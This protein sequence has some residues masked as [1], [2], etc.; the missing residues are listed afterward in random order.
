MRLSSTP[1]PASPRTPPPACRPQTLSGVMLRAE[2]GAVELQAT[3][4]EIGIRVKVAAEVE[5]EGT[6]VLP[7]RLLLDVVRSLPNDDLSLEYQSSRQDVE[8]ISGAARFHLRT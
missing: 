8:V 6:V 3:D 5:R 1:T 4:M 7:G 2:G